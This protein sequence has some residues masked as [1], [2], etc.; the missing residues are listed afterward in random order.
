MITAK[1]FFFSGRVQGVGFRYRTKRL[2]MGFDLV[3]WVKNLNDG[4]V[5]MQVMGEPD[6]I[7]DFLEEMH[8]SPLGHHIQ[9]QEE[10]TIPELENVSGFS[11]R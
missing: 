7:N 1:Q 6:E 11:I 3:G 5:E 8:D 9:E 4:R 2:A 10:R